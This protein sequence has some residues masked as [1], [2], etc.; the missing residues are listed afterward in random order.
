M[1]NRLA[2]VLHWLGF[3]LG[4]VVFGALSLDFIV[5]ALPGGSRT[6]N[7]L[8]LVVPIVPLILGWVLR[9][10]L[11]GSKVVFPWSKQKVESRP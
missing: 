3:L 1:I 4:A 8:G 10:I 2:L 9:F 6:I 5:S 11:T 7:N